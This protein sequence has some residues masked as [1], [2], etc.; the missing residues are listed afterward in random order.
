MEGFVVAERQP[1]DGYRAT[2]SREANTDFRMLSAFLSRQRLAAYA[3]EETFGGDRDLYKVLGFPKDLRFSHYLQLY[4]RHDIAGRLVDLPAEDTWRRPP[5]VSE[6]GDLN[7]EFS[8]AWDYLNRSLRIFS[9]L[10]T[11][12]RL[13][14]IGRFGVMLIGVRDGKPLHSAVAEHSLKSPKDVLY[15][16]PFHE[17]DVEIAEWQEDTQDKRYNLPEIYTIQVQEDIEEDVHW[18]RILHMAENKGSND[19]YGQ[20]RL[21]RAYNQFLNKMKIGGG[22]A[23]AIWYA[24]RPGMVISEREGYDPAGLMDDDAFQEEVRRYMH[25]P[26][27]ILRLIGA[28]AKEIAAPRMLDPSGAAEVML[29]YISAS[30][31]IPKR[32]L[33]GSAHGQLAAAKEDLRQWYA[34]VAFRQKN[35]AEPEVLRPFIDRL[36]W[37]GVLPEPAGGPDAYHIGSKSPNDEWEWPALLQLDDLEIARIREARARAARNLSDVNASYPITTDEMR[38]LLGL[39]PLREDQELPAETLPDEEP[40]EETPY[41]EEPEALERARQNYREGRIS[42]SALADLVAGGNG[43]HHRHKE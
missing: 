42:A 16:R 19:A 41:H 1:F 5:T 17:G 2:T 13:S 22:V 3:G 27:R 20:P 18:T 39:R 32:V 33:I 9:K 40:T 26:A 15:L 21:Q 11:T 36:I 14:G 30:Q 29:G 37:M 28:E 25:D 34:H 12:D 24:M 38:R 31:G 6:D 4:E 23:E 7:T 8:K 35:Y 43:G 10:S